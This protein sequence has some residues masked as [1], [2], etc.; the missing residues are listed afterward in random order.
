MYKVILSLSNLRW[1]QG[2]GIKGSLSSLRWVWVLDVVVTDHGY[3]SCH[4]RAFFQ[5]GQVLVFYEHQS[6]EKICFN[7]LNGSLMMVK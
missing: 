1:D 7:W 3:D 6:F 5:K 4:K 2:W